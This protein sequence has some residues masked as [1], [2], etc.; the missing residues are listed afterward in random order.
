MTDRLRRAADRW[1][2]IVGLSDRDAVSLIERRSHR[3]TRRSRWAY[4]VQSVANARPSTGAY[5]SFLAGFSWTD[6]ASLR[7]TISSWTNLPCGPARSVGTTEA[8]VRLP[9]GRFCYSPPDYAPSPTDPPSLRRDFV[10]FGSFN[11]ISKIGPEVIG[12]WAA[13]LRAVPTSRLL[14][15]WRSLD[16]E[17]TRRRLSDAFA[18]AGVTETRL[19]FQNHSSHPELMAQYGEIDI[20]LDPFPYSGGLTSC[21]AFWMGVPVV[22]LTRRPRQLRGTSWGTSMLLGLGDCVASSPRDYVDRA[23]RAGC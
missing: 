9:Y 23:G 13:V 20:A 19:E 8:V 22:T 4:F 1:R 11:N 16:D 10:T 17:A 2:S 18:A 3:H 21:E 15:K 14:F 12:L 5:P 7:S 6:R